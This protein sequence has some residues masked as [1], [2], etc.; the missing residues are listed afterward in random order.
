MPKWL[1]WV[2]IPIAFLV[3]IVIAA[4]FLDEPLRAYAERE[5]NQRLPAYTIHI[6]ALDLHPLALSLD[7]EDVVVRQKERSDPPLA[8]VS[9]IH[10]SLQW[11]A[12][13][14]GRLVTD[15]QIDHPVIHF[16]RPQAAKE[17]E[18]P[19]EKKQSWQEAL[20]AMQEIQINEVRITNGEVSYR[21]TTTS[22]PMRITDLN[23]KAENIRNVR[24][25]AHEY[26]SDIHIDAVVFEKGKFT[27]DGHADFFAEPSLAVNAD[28]TLTDIELA[29]LQPLTAQHQVYFSQG[30]LSADGHVEYAP[31]V[32]EAR[33][34]TFGLHEVKGDFIHTAEAV[35]KEKEPGKKAAQAAKQ[36]TN[37][38]TLLVRI[39]DGKIKNCEFG[40]VNQAASP[41]YRMFISG[42]DVDLENWSNRLSE[43]TATVKLHGLLMGSGATD[44]TGTFRPETKSPDFDLHVKIL[45]T[46]AKS[47]NPALRAHSGTDVVAGVFSVFS[48]MTV[49]DGQ[50]QG[51]LKPL[52]KDV[53]AYDPEQDK[54]KG[55]LTKI[56]EKTIDVASS[57]FKNTRGEVATKADVA[58][59]VENPQASTWEMVA[60]LFSNAFFDAVLPGLE[61]KGKL[62]RS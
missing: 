8:A 41:S 59:P 27:L 3:V 44:I 13:L 25:K 55:L 46:P 51:Y 23:V 7:L 57:V 9:K 58:G 52:Y 61:G 53:T 17:L 39:D 50:V 33:L 21:E 40:I 14:R 12:L 43:G 22:K 2:A 31:T 5:M 6:G 1:W 15:E 56:F 48:E 35:K 47:L 42:T 45:K 10:G 32:Q 37:R 19:P 28:L 36:A 26:P 29:A 54:D 49:K 34:R 11:S 20:F 24:S 18:A 16:T 38:P 4:S 60:T 30:R 62:E